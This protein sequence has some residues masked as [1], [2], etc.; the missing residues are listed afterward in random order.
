MQKSIGRQNK[1]GE[2]ATETMRQRDGE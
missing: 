2:S 1:L